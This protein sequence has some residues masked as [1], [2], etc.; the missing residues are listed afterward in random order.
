MH[1]CVPRRCFFYVSSGVFS[2][3]VQLLSLVV[4]FASVERGSRSVKVKVVAVV[5][6]LDGGTHFLA[7]LGNWQ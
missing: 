4:V 5:F 6:F 1:Y 3:L 2:T 7:F